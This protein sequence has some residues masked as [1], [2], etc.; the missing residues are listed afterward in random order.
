[1]CMHIFLCNKTMYLYLDTKEEQGTIFNLGW[2]FLIVVI[3]KQTIHDTTNGIFGSAIGI[4][5]RDK[6]YIGC[7]STY[8]RNGTKFTSLFVFVVSVIMKMQSSLKSIILFSNLSFLFD[9]VTP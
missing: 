5:F 1:M 7:T 2:L 3:N 6:S 8:A 9:S 4:Y